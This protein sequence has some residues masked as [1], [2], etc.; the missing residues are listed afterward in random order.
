MSTIQI[1]AMNAVL[2]MTSMILLWLASLRLKDAS[3]VDIFWG[4][5]F[6]LIAWA[7]FAVTSGGLRSMLVVAV[8]TI[9]GLRLAIYLAWRNHGKGE[10]ARYKAMRD[11]RGDSF[12]WVSLI[13]VFALQGVV[14]WLVSMPIQI[15]QTDATPFSVLNYAG[16]IVWAIGFL[17]E[18]LGDYQLARFKSS[19]QADWKVMDQGLWRYTRHPNYFGNALIWW[20]IF[21]MS[22]SSST[23]WLAFSPILMTFLLLRVS[24]VA[25]LEKSLS[26]RSQEYRDYVRR[27]SA[28]CPW[29]PNSPDAVN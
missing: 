25:L 13:T 29:P 11:G 7:T 23:L 17:F 2:I 22:A 15:G 9:W 6:V 26:S 19:A 24:G 1:L 28:F 21:G 16:A 20:G 14:M 10:D 4:L 8:T 18:S 27:T 12:W 5:G 3:I